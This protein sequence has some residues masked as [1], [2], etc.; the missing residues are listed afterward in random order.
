[1]HVRAGR[2]TPLPGYKTA[3][4]QIGETRD[5]ARLEMSWAKFASTPG[6]LAPN[7]HSRKPGSVQSLLAMNPSQ[8][9]GVHTHLEV[10]QK[11]LGLKAWGLA[12]PT[13]V[14]SMFRRLCMGINPT[15]HSVSINANGKVMGYVTFRLGKTYRRDYFG[16]R[17]PKEILDKFK[18]TFDSARGEQNA[19]PKIQAAARRLLIWLIKK[20][21]V[22]V[23]VTPMQGYKFYR[24]RFVPK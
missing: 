21:H 22:K 15:E 13:D 9:S 14:K 18:E 1:M 12:S 19:S 6:V 10:E 11:N 7:A 16:K 5:I 2:K 23:R 20:K 8:K 17:M 4:Q 24:G 3:S